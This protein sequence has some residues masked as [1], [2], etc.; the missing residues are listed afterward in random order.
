MSKLI[1]V[2]GLPGSGKTTY[3]KKLADA[4]NCA[5]YEADQFF[6]DANG[7]YTFDFNKLTEAHDWCYDRVND[8]LEKDLDVVVSNTFT[9]LREI[10]HY[11]IDGSVR[12]YDV[13]IYQ[14]TR[15]YGSI[16]DVPMETVQR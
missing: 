3:A 5:H 9:T 4:L 16:H 14:M 7:V 13:V 10:D 8:E 1:I 12:G 15:Y 6:T 11:V 2:R